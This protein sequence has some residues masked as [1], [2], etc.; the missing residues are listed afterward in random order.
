MQIEGPVLG[1]NRERSPSRAMDTAFLHNANSMREKLNQVSHSLCLAKWL[2]VSLHL[3]TGRTQSCY[4]PPTHTIPKAEIERDPSA[5]H[6]TNFKK[7]QRQQML[8]GVRPSECQYCWAIEDTPGD[9]LSDRH[10]RSAESW[11]APHFDEVLKKGANEN[12]NP[13]AVEVNFSSACQLKCSYCSP[14]ISSAWLDEVKRLGPFPLVKGA[15]NDLKYLKSAGLMPIAKS[16][17][18]PY[19]KA[20]W[21]WWPDLYKDLSVFR[22]TGGEPLMDVNTFRVLDYIR[23]N[24][25]PNLTLALTSNFCVRDEYMEKFLTKITPLVNGRYVGAFQ[26]YVSCDSVGA[27]A[28]YIRHGLNYDKF[29]SNVDRYLTEV[30]AG[31]VTFIV[32]FNNLSV[33]GWRGLLDDILK[34]RR[35]HSRYS[36]RVFFDTPLLRFPKWQSLPILPERYQNILVEDIAY[37]RS[38]QASFE[39]VESRFHRVLDFEVAR[40][41]RNLAWMMQPYSETE[42]REL[43]SNFYAFFKAHDQRRGTDFLKAFPEMGD[44]WR[45]CQ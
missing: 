13:R 30:R 43:R 20:F 32:T 8:S 12:I 19:T 28:E 39:S 40:M 2:Q 15:H 33:T 4:H 27:K 21:K 7:N 18:N 41:E 44:F 25:K 9:H 23:E 26:L 10:Y 6:N 16:E 17:D 3:T 29:L 36:Q 42:T 1:A 11:S 31:T 14:H 35:K 24:P 38:Q 22:M 37:M 34:L 45:L 5:L